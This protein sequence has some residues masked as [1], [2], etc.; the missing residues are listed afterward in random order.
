MSHGTPNDDDKTRSFKIVEGGTKIGQYTI[1]EKIGEGGMGEVYLADDNSLK[2]RVALKF[3]P[4]ELANDE[5]AKSRFKREARAAASLDH[6]NIVQVYEVGEFEG[7]PFF[8]MQ[9]VEGNSLKDII[10]S[11]KLTFDE[12][13][14]IGIQVCSGLQTAH[15]RNVV[16]RD[17]KPANILIDSSRRARILDFGLAAVESEEALTQAGSTL[18]TVGYMSP[19]QVRGKELDGRSDV[20][21]TGVVLYELL[22]RNAPFKT[23]SQIGTINAILND[24]P[25]PAS[26]VNSQS[27]VGF[28]EII[29]KALDKDLETRYQSASGMLADLKR[30]RK[31]LDP[32]ASSGSFI[33]SQSSSA[34]KA[35]K[36]LGMPVIVGGAVLIIAAVVIGIMTIGG[37]DSGSISHS[38]GTKSAVAGEWGHS[39]AVL[40]FRDFS[41]TRDQEFFCD[42]MTDAI[43]G[44]LSAVNDLKV[45]SMTSVMR[46][47]SEERD[48]KKIGKDLDVQTILEG[49]VQKEGDNVRVRV[50]LVDVGNEASLLTKTYDKELESIFAIQDEISH[51][52]VDV[53]KLE[54]LGDQRASMANRNSS[55]VEAFNLY[56]QGR[57]EWRKRNET[58]LRE[59]IELFDESTKLDPNYAL[60]WSG[61][62]DAWSVLPGY[63]NFPRDSANFFAK[64]AVDRALEL[65]PNLAEAHASMGLHL[66][67]LPKREEAIESYERAIELNPSYS[68]AHVWYSNVLYDLS[69]NEEG[70]KQLELAYEL[71]PMSLPTLGNLSNRRRNAGDFE[72]AVELLEKAL[73]IEETSTILQNYANLLSQQGKID[74]AIEK[75]KRAIELTPTMIS[76]YRGLSSMYTITDELDKAVSVFDPYIDR[77]PEDSR[78]YQARGNLLALFGRFKEAIPDLQRALALGGDPDMAYKS[79]AI[80][81]IFDKQFEKSLQFLEH[82]ISMISPSDKQAR[83]EMR[84]GKPL[85]LAYQGKYDLAIAAMNEA[86]EADT[87]EQTESM[88]PTKH[89]LLA[90]FYTDLRRDS[91]ALASYETYL[92]EQK[93]L[94]PDNNT[95]HAEDYCEIL[96]RAGQIDR[97][98]EIAEELKSCWEEL[99]PRAVGRYYLA[100]GLIE[101]E[102]GAYDKAVDY[103]VQAADFS[104]EKNW[105]YSK[106]ELAFLQGRSL[107]MGGHADSAAARLESVENFYENNRLNRPAYAFQ[108]FYYLGRACEEIGDKER[109]RSYYEEFLAIC[110]DGDDQ[111]K[112]ISDARRRLSKLKGTS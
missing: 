77:F 90:M 111:V 71:D 56:N 63:S 65:Q 10:S 70:L 39:I 36:G 51:S 41:S 105:N 45:I 62:A 66:M 59:S 91:L 53:L 18:G 93:R 43:I 100:R 64:Q 96:A 112:E 108:I 60:A 88:I 16:H 1:I 50:Q 48:L 20:F 25:Q 34:I 30:L 24:T 11:D 19:E 92:S 98:L 4:Q 109:A 104:K 35:R 31:V 27:P 12:I 78:G 73:S 5:N 103:F 58:A 57:I 6:P 97:A 80:A 54:L 26:S 75:Y 44:K 15:E 72:A 42:G 74:E 8:A 67:S 101:H 38:I 33:A 83:S 2:R 49:S 76:L 99:N 89:G 29:N 37:S 69:R 107:F 13:L 47:K 40:P 17:I 86:I 7:R 46:Y 79:Y 106:F 9:Y 81:L 23:E 110:G 87:R 55:N 3:L 102:L 32:E 68:W 21:S 94:Y 52:I 28:D 22:T 14:D 82:G 95:C 84:M 85:V 61:L